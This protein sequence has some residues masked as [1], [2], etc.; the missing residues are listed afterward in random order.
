MLSADPS[1]GLLKVCCGIFEQ[2][3]LTELVVCLQ[4]SK[5]NK[6]TE[7]L[8]GHMLAGFLDLSL[9]GDPVRIVVREV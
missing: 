7:R 1:S 4:L 5:V 2:V 9:E 6:L 3:V 8:V